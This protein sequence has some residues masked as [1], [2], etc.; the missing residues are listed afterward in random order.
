MYPWYDYMDP[1]I[2]NTVNG[3]EDKTSQRLHVSYFVSTVAG[4]SSQQAV[5]IAGYMRP[6][7]Y[8]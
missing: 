1:T 3:K 6:I 5:Q 2:N 8:H 4:A 7:V